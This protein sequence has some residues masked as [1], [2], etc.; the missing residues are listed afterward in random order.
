LVLKGEGGV[1]GLK[2][3][4]NFSMGVQIPFLQKSIQKKK[5][6]KESVLTSCR[7]QTVSDWGKHRV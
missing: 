5:R 1:M 3:Q 2:I 4:G 6:G 7:N